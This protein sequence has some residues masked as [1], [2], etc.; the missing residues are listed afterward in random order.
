MF[1]Q[2]AFT[3]AWNK[4]Q[5]VDWASNRWP[6]QPVVKFKKMKTAQIIAMYHNS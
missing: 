5:W 1:R 4:R 2:Q 6:S 3:P